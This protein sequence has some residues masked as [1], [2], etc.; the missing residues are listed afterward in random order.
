[1][2]LALTFSLLAY[3]AQYRHFFQVSLFTG[4]YSRVTYTHSNTLKG[5]KQ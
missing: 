2:P 4:I 3:T 5:K 1:M